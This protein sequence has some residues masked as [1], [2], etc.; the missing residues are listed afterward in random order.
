MY[1]EFFL[2]LTLPGEFH[3]SSYEASMKEIQERWNKVMVILR[4][5]GIIILGIKK[6]HLHKNETPQIHATLYFKPE[7]ED[8]IR[9]VVFSFFTNDKDR[10]DKA[11]QKTDNNK[12]VIQYLFKDS[13]RQY[14]EE[15][16]KIRFIGLRRNI[17][18]VWDN[19]DKKIM[20]IRHFHIFPITVFLKLDVF[21]TLKRMKKISCFF[22]ALLQNYP[23]MR[24]RSGTLI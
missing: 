21:W 12:F 15:I 4:K 18:S 22:F 2:T 17:S 20:E 5:K 10:E 9:E 3:V 19:F 6:I 24:F 7:Y 13:C 11:F 8:I 1:E 16:C 23:S 14:D